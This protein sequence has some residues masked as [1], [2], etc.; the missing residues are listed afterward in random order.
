MHKLCVYYL[1]YCKVI[2][3]YHVYVTYD[4]AKYY[5]NV[6]I[7]SDNAEYYI[8]SMGLLSMILLCII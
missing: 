3:I 5:K 1:G 8:C 7:A 2:N 4:A 6:Y